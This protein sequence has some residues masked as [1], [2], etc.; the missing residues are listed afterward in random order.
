MKKL[1]IILFGSLCLLPVGCQ[2]TEIRQELAAVDDQLPVALADGVTLE[3]VTLEESEVLMTLT[4]VGPE[5]Q[6]AARDAGQKE[7]FAIQLYRRWLQGMAPT[8]RQ[9]L[10]KAGCSVRFHVLFKPSGQWGD[11]VIANSDL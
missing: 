8:M 3:S 10:K 5:F 7:A 9:R 1:F 11:Y 4:A 2:L 6:T